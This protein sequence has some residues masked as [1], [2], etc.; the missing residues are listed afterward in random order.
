MPELIRL[1]LL[2][3]YDGSQFS[4]WAVQPGL[5]TVQGEIEHAVGKILRRENDVRLTVA[6]RTDAGV[7]ARGQVAHLDVTPAEL[8][9]W[10]GK[11]TRIEDSSAQ[12]IARAQ[13]LTG[14]LR[15]A[16]PDIVIWRADEV[17]EDFNARF[18]ALWRRYEYRISVGECD[19][20]LR[21]MTASVKSEIDFDV[22]QAASEQLT[23][24]RDFST[25]CKAREGATAV[26]HL[27]H[28][29]WERESDRVFVARIEAD[30][31]CHSMVRALVGAAVAAAT[32]RI[33]ADQVVELADAQ[34]R[35]SMF[36]VMPAHGLS[37]QEIGYPNDAALAARAV[38]TRARRDPL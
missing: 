19:P 18:S 25:F 26:R 29:E 37:L 9:K 7:H 6:G 23:G 30:A 36:T 28:F 21:Q 11:A 13:K 35:S 12:S 22:L 38:Q 24:L 27:T 10:T 8:E 5:R 34:E 16:A 14:V 2:L 31:F 32:G 3:S 1:K 17:S 4:G 15:K 33:T 20:L